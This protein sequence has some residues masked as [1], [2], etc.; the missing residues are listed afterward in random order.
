[1]RWANTII[2]VL[3]FAAFIA[4]GVF[5][6][7]FI[8][9]AGLSGYGETCSATSQCM[10]PLRCVETT[11]KTP[12][13]SK[14]GDFYWAAGNA[15]AQRADVD[16]TIANYDKAVARYEADNVNVPPEL[17]CEYGRTLRYK[18]GDPK[19]AEMAARMLHR[20]VLE[21]LPG[22]RT[23]QRGLLELSQLE[24][25]GLDPATLDK[26]RLSDAYLTLQPQ[27][28]ATESLEIAIEQNKNGKGRGYK[29]FV[30]ALKDAPL[31]D[32]LGGC[33]SRYWL[34]TRNN[35]MAVSLDAEYTGRYDDFDEVY[36]PG[37]LKLDPVEAGTDPH[38]EAGRCVA[39]QVRQALANVSDVQ[40]GAGWKGSIVVS[41]A[42]GS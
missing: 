20:C 28:P 17:L 4:A 2:L 27:A 32:A 24:M 13:T 35:T 22:T 25:L 40:Q 39:A 6:F 36:L 26:P 31:R 10:K 11:C 42:A 18:N 19:A 33:F 23:Y 16:A 37:E 21:A 38:G 8:S 12:W 5:S 30:K 15:A 3:F 9:S 14:L 7:P 34:A 29:T 41:V 1:M